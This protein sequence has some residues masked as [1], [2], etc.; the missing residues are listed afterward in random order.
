MAELT[1]CPTCKQAVSSAAETCPHCG[2]PLS[3]GCGKRKS[4]LRWV[5]LG[6]G[7]IFA[8]L[9]IAFVVNGIEVMN[10][11]GDSSISTEYT[12]PA[13]MLLCLGI[14]IAAAS[15]CKKK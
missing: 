6:F 1:E 7:T 9:G 10:I 15:F 8:V 4:I 3:S 2:Q 13:A 11:R 5:F 14:F 12:T